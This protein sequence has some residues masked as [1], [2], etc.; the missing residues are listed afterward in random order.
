MAQQLE[1]VKRNVTV[2]P[3]MIGKKVMIHNGQKSRP[4]LVTKNHVGLKFGEFIPTKKPA[5]YKTLLK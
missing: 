4:L 1:E 5:I 2:L 3:E